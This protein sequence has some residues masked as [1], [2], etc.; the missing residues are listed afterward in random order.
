LRDQ[1]LPAAA[2]RRNPRGS[3]NV[4]PHIS[5][6]RD[7]RFTGMHAD[8]HADRPTF[9][10]CLRVARG[11]QRVRRAGESDEKRI[12]LR[13]HLDTAVPA[14][15][16]AQDSTVLGQHVGVLVAEL[17]QKSRRAFDVGEE[18][19]SPSRT[20][21]AARRNHALHARVRHGCERLRRRAR[22]SRAA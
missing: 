16:L 5:L 9:E 2:G 3:M 1:D 15:G 17:V 7:H 20:E 14:E 12:A 21:A 10:L 11:R 19:R 22:R 13:V 18:K 4:D 8:P 6:V